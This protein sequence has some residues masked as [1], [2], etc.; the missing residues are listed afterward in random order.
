MTETKTFADFGVAED[1]QAALADIDIT[2]PF[3]IQELTLPLG[4]AGADVIGQ[5]RTGTGKTLAFGIPL[6]HRVTDDPRTQ[7]LVVVPTRELCMQVRDDLQRAS[8]RRGTRVI[9]VYGGK[10]IDAQADAIRTGSPIVVGTPGRL[11]DLLRRG[12]LDLSTVRMLVLDEADEMLDLGFLPDVEVLIEACGEDRQTLL[13]SA[14]MPSA[15]VALARRYMRKP[16]FLRAEVEE[17]RIAPET[18]QHFFSCHRMDK[19]AV[20]ARILQTPGRGLCVVFTRTKRMADVLASELRERGIVAA[21]IHSDL[22]QEARERALAKFRRGTIDVLVATEVAARGLDISDVTHVV[23]Y[24]CPDDEKMY[25]HRI[26][27][28]GRAGGRGVAVTLAVWNELARLE[29]IKKALAID[30]PT[31]EVFSTSPILD[32]LFDLPERAPRK[33][34]PQPPATARRSPRRGRGDAGGRGDRGPREAARDPD[35]RERPATPEQPAAREAGSPAARRV[36][37]RRRSKAAEGDPGRPAAAEEALAAPEATAAPEAPPAAAAP[38]A[39]EGRSVGTRRRV[40]TRTG[41]RAATDGEPE[42]AGEAAPEPASPTSEPEAAEGSPRTRRSRA[43]ER[44]PRRSRGTPRDAQGGAD[45]ARRD[46]RASGDARGRRDDRASGDARGRRDERASRDARGRRD[47]RA[48][49]DGRGRRAR[50]RKPRPEPRVD[51]DRATVE[52]ARGSGKPALNRPMAVT[53][54]P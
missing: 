9:P 26:G 54:L 43:A 25:L 40:R 39:A 15:V 8:A 38:A 53:H 48:S 19:P 12:I 4:L 14:T 7:A 24:D 50:P 51:L 28:T 6:L 21:P 46:E 1:I 33:P 31:H 47:E 18:E 44:A 35:A 41:G 42:A 10:A 5:A 29:M 16:T 32:E 20:L 52:R 45:D 34:A 17:A 37:A 23:N 27:R 13:F 30:A 49:G 22:R 36:R 3:P 2:S 11:L